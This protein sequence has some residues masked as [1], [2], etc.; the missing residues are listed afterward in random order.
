MGVGICN[1]CG[2]VKERY[3]WQK[4]HFK[5]NFNRKDWIKYFRVKVTSK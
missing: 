2:K 5:T 4:N 1:I 3:H